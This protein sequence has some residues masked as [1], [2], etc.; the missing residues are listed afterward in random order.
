MQNS[1]LHVKTFSNFNIN[2]PVAEESIVSKHSLIDYDKDQIAVVWCKHTTLEN[3]KDA[4]TLLLENFERE[5]CDCFDMSKPSTVFLLATQELN[6]GYSCSDRWRYI[7]VV[8]TVNNIIE[9]VWIHPFF[10]NRGIMQSFLVNYACSEGMLQVAPP[11]SK[12]MN[13]CI[14]RSQEKVLED[15]DLSKLYVNNIAKFLIENGADKEE[16]K[17]L[18]SES[19]YRVLA[20]LNTYESMKARENIECSKDLNIFSMSV[21]CALLCQNN[22]EMVEALK[23]DPEM[24]KYTLG[25]ENIFE[26]FRKYGNFK[27]SK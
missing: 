3:I 27:K 9:I 7:G 24:I 13:Y 21:K 19:I 14:E 26:D 11:L 17:L 25:K 6:P 8:I 22:P 2:V 10:R 16:V 5:C 1:I 20:T 18:N 23:N 12:I 15:K 4:Y